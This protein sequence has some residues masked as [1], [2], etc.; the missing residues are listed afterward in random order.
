MAKRQIP[1]VSYIL[2]TFLSALTFQPC[3]KWKSARQHHV[4]KTWKSARQH[5]VAKNME[6]CKTASCSKNIFISNE[7][8]HGHHR[9][10]V[11]SLEHV[12]EIFP[13]SC[14]TQLRSPQNRPDDSSACLLADLVNS[15]GDCLLE[16]WNAARFA[17]VHNALQLSS[18]RKIQRGQVW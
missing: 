2:D 10:I 13:F 9:D 15:S 3:D 12:L 6:K 17:A 1:G 4:A 16:L 14:E 7:A 18:K 8:C 11:R 5:H